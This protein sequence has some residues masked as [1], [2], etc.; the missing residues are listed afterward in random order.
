MPNKFTPALVTSGQSSLTVSTSPAYSSGDCIGGLLTFQVPPGSFALQSVTV[1]DVDAQA[2]ALSVIFFESTPAGTTTDNTALT[3]STDRLKIL[4][5]VAVAATD[6]VAVGG[7]SIAT[8]KPG[9]FTLQ[10]TSGNTTLYAAIGT[11]STPTFTNTTTKF[12]V[13]VGLVENSR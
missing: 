5:V 13:R 9:A 4:G 12:A 2:P 11:T 1:T 6:Y 8:V 3:I 10:P 7:V